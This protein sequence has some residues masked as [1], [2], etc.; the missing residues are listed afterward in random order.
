ME[1]GVEE[2]MV[3][4]EVDSEGDMDTTEDM[5]EEDSTIEMEDFIGV[6]M[7]SVLH[8]FLRILSGLVQLS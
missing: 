8:G 6:D 5:E 3:E 1:T 4:G 7:V 2:V